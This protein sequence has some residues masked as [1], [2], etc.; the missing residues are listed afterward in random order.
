MTIRLCTR[1]IMDS[2]VPGIRFDAQGVCNYCHIHD[3]LLVEFPTGEEGARILREIAAKIRKAGKGRQYDCVV[4]VSGG[5]DTSYCLYYTKEIMNLRPL[6]VH[7]DNGWD[8]ETAKTNLS[9]VCDALDVDLHTIIMDWPESRE[10]T[11]CTIRACVPYIDLTDDV[12]IASA[13]YRTAAKENVRYIILSHSFREEGI[14]PLAWNYM[15]ARYTR[16]LIKRFCAIPLVHFKNVDIHHML[17]WSLVKGIRI[18][19]ITNYYDDTGDKI[20]KLLTDRFGWIDTGQHHMDNEMFALV[21]YYA[22]HKFGFDWRIVELAAKVRTGVVSRD[23]ALQALQTIPFFENEELVNYCLKKQGF[24]REEF[25]RILAA[26]NKYF[27][28][29]PTYYPLLRF[30]RLPI[31]L[32]CRAHVFPAHAYEK[33]FEAI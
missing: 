13:L 21:Y 10:L 7:F 9:R 30:M 16:A 33:Y 3:R 17:Y 14:T 18:V 31:K 24:S 26:P 6:A 27:Y 2:S 1:C 23:E 32:L 12:G 22:R 11:N 19:N 29:Y 28:D 20:E 25:D 4:G 5:R 8:S 15:D